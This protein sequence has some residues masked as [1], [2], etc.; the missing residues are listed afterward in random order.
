M[1]KLV[2]I[3]GSPRKH[4]NTEIIIKEVLKT[5][6]GEGAKTEL[7]HLTDFNL[8]PCDACKSCKVTKTCIINDDVEKLFNLIEMS[9]GVVIGSPVYFYSVSAQTKIFMDRVG[10]LHNARG[11]NPFRHKIGGAVAV[12]SGTGVTNTISQILMFLTSA[13]MI[14]AAPFVP[15]IGS[16]KGD[17][18]KDSR[19][20]TYARELGRSMVQLVKT[21]VSLREKCLKQK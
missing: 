2:G 13:R 1:V 11:K 16:D 15:A 14:T 17:V 12:A 20:L 21:T 8:K 10:Y 18:L 3:V 19:G 7:I 4:G 5:A 6:E 9:D